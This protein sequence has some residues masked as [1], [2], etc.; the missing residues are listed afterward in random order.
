VPVMLSG[1]DNTLFPAFHAPER[2]AFLRIGRLEPPRMSAVE[3]DS[4]R[5]AC[6]VIA[7][8]CPPQS[9]PVP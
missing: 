7:K 2:F 4:F 8:S 1:D 9:R 6:S 5:V 3:R